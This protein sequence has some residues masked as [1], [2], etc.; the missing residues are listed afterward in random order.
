MYVN[1]PPPGPKS[2]TL[3]SMGQAN[4]QKARTNS[5]EEKAQNNIVVG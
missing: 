1:K 5:N 4:E 3:K 2:K